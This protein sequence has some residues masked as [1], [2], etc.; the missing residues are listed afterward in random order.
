M[1]PAWA[2]RDLFQ[3]ASLGVRLVPVTITAG[4]DSHEGTEGWRVPKRD[5][6][7]AVQV[8]LQRRRLRI[9]QRLAEAERLLE[10]M[11]G[12]R[13]QITATGRDTYGAGPEGVHD[14]LG[15]WYH[16]RRLTA[17]GVRQVSG[18]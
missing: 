10:E 5:L 15:A 1:R 3:A 13:V 6:V 17:P 11:E 8:L 7:G 9:A 18:W 12:F 2:R 4:A 16:S 14:D